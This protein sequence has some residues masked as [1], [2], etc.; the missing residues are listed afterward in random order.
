MPAGGPDDRLCSSRSGREQMAPGSVGWRPDRPVRFGFPVTPVIRKPLL[1]PNRAVWARDFHNGRLMSAGRGVGEWVREREFSNP[2]PSEGDGNLGRMEIPP[3]IRALIVLGAMV[4][5]AVFVTLS[6]TVTVTLAITSV[7]FLLALVSLTG[8][9]SALA[10]WKPFEPRPQLELELELSGP[11][12]ALAGAGRP[13]VDVEA[14][15][16]E[17]VEAAWQTAPPPPPDTSLNRMLGLSGRNVNAMAA[18]SWDRQAGASKLESFGKRVD[19]YQAELRAWLNELDEPIWTRCS[20]LEV[21]VVVRNTATRAAARDLDVDVEIAAGL[22]ESVG[23]AD[24]DQPPRR[25]DFAESRFPQF[26]APFVPHFPSQLPFVQPEN[27]R[28][29]PSGSG[30]RWSVHLPALL[31]AGT[32]EPSSDLEL[33]AAEPGHY[34]LT[35]AARTSGLPQAVTQSVTVEIPHTL[36]RR[37]ATLRELSEYLDLE[38]DDEDQA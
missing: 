37:L 20:Q 3:K 16:E 19:K 13:W 21:R 27:V 5:V 12:R 38:V 8:L 10:G 9:A 32:T 6:L 4:L 11:A 26:M 15:V 24:P 23:P 7:G 35:A 33:Q 17:Q 36:G 28:S 22:Q 25:P 29:D 2:F 30:S 14:I 18:E 34:E 31:H 1:P